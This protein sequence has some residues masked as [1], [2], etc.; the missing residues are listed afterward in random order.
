M[1]SVITSAIACALIVAFLGYYVITLDAVPLWIVVVAVLG[2]AI[3]DFV[4]TARGD[5]VRGAR[6]GRGEGGGE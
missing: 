1:I 6:D 5:K 2:M 3:A 4:L